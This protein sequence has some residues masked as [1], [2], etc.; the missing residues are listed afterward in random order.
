MN[1]GQVIRQIREARNATLEEI[2]HIADTNASNLSRIERGVQGYSADTLERIA[3]ALGV[4]VAELHLRTQAIDSVRG[5]SEFA[6]NVESMSNA[7]A[8][9]R[10]NSLTPEHRDLADDFIALLLRRQKVKR[11]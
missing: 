10:Y 5:A 1:I 3:A 2:A 6:T 8:A 4:K 9:N 7:I 11:R